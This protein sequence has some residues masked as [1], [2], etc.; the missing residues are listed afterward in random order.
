MKLEIEVKISEARLRELYN[1]IVILSDTREK[2]DQH[3]LEYFKFKGIKYEEK[4][5]EVGDYS[6]MIKKNDIFNQDI[7]FTNHLSIER[8][9]S[10]EE[11]SGN[12]SEGRLAFE[13]E[14]ALML[15]KK[16]DSYL[17]IEGASFQDVLKGNYKTD[18]NKNAYIGS[19][20]S[21][22]GRYKISPFFIP[23][24]NTGE[25]IYLLCKYNFRNLVK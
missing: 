20:M 4:K 6:Y 9:N 8:K 12:L 19:L 21:F 14:L 24:E 2:K 25:L 11:L 5:L 7:Y 15:D 13:N 23:K 18:Y 1:E 10:L 22:I 17:I 3:I 16:L